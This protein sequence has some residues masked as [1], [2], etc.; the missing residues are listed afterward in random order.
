MASWL[1]RRLIGVCLMT[2]LL[3]G[4]VFLLI[5]LMPGD[6]VDMMIADNPRLTAADIAR[7]RAA[8]GVDQPLGTRFIA[9]LGSVAQGDFGWSRLYHQPVTS[10][11]GPRLVETLTLTGTALGLSLL[12]GGGLGLIAALRPASWLAA[13]IEFIAT[14]S[15]SLPAFWL[16]LLLIWLFAVSLGWLPATGTPPAA[17]PW[18]AS[19]RWAILPILSLLFLHLGGP[20]RMAGTTLA[21]VLRTDWLRTARAKGCSRPRVILIHALPAALLPLVTMAALSLGALFSG[22]LVTETIFARPGIGR[23]INE[24]ILGNDYNLA[25]AAL[26]LAGV[27]VF[28]ANLLADIAI[29]LL[30]PRVSLEGPA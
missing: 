29:L 15:L 9:W 7:L 20:I 12:I 17:P 27:M 25:L 5:G 1:T 14:T 8:Y 13:V 18:P 11:L 2:L 22:A 30:D 4:L 23:L 28:I 6:P 3:A 16:A 24:A 19:I 26:L 21:E 10:V